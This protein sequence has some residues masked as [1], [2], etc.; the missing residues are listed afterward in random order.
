MP[1]T[2]ENAAEAGRKGNEK[3]A[4]IQAILS[5]PVYHPRDLHHP[6]LIMLHEIITDKHAKAGDRIAA[7]RLAG[8]FKEADW[9]VRAQQSSINVLAQ[10]LSEPQSQSDM[11][12]L[13]Q[14]S[15]PSLAQ[16]DDRIV[17]SAT[18]QADNVSN[19]QDKE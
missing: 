5:L 3:R 12:A 7:G 9:W 13:A 2:K 6:T 19:I 1:F 10:F 18:P 14:V 11:R 16:G 8:E 17:P 4:Q 15:A